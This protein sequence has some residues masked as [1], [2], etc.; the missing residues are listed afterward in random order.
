M[1][2]TKS[3]LRYPGGKT[4]LSKFLTNLIELNYMTDVIYCEPFS[5]GFG[6]GLDLLSSGHASKVII[7]D[8]DLGIYSVWFA[9]LNDYEIFINLVKTVPVTIEEWYHQKE[10]Y[11]AL[12]NTNF[13][14]IELAFATFFLNRTN[15]S[16][17]IQGGPIGGRNQKSKY[18]IDCRYNKEN[19]IKKIKWINSH[20]SKIILLNYEANELIQKV[21][22][23]I[24]KDKLFTF[25]DPP[26]YKQGKNLYTNFFNHENHLELKQCIELMGYFKWI[27]TYDNEE[28]IEQIYSDFPSLRYQIRYSANRVRKETE[29]LF[30][31]KNTI[32]SSFD[33]VQFK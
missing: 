20:K 14:S 4:Q 30:H 28:N 27:V 1:A 32:V 11:N 6:A 22:L 2:T 13:Y 9:I 26:Y 19:L 17:I 10:I 8:I 29:L 5:G 23:K 18:L 31:S 7:N 12:I 15:I 25:F 24:D 21:L 33:K 3:P 16:G